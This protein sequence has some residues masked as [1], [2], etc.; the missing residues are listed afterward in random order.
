MFQYLEIMDAAR[1]S[2]PPCPKIGTYPNHHPEREQNSQKA[3]AVMNMDPLKLMCVF[4]HPDDESLGMGAVLAKYASE[5]VETYL[6]TAT[7][8]EGGWTGSPETDPG[9]KALGQIREAE[10]RS[11]VEVLGIC[12][13]EILDYIDGQLEHADPLQAAAQIARIMREVRPQV[14]VS[15]CPEGA[16]GHPDHIAISH[17]TAAALVLAADPD[18]LP[19]ESLPPH[20]GQK[21]YYMVDSS[22]SADLIQSMYGDIIG[23]DVDGVRRTVVSWPDWAITARVQ[24]FEHVRT[25]LKASNCHKSQMAGLPPFDSLPQDSLTALFGENSFVRV[26]SLVNGGQTTESDLFSGLR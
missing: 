19:Q 14:V 7:R 10:L 23:I 9:P 11:A 6:I 15:F 22:R 4:A 2:N 26:Y 12:R 5:G 16:Y 17:Y 18:F 25:G 1:S 24:A 8:G 3:A 13:V 20:R 21:F